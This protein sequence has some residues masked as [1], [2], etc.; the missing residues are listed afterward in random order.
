MNTF[1][2]DFSNFIL[3]NY[4]QEHDKIKEEQV[5][6]CIKKGTHDFF[7]KKFYNEHNK[8]VKDDLFKKIVFNTL[9]KNKF[10]KYCE[11]FNVF[12]T[13]IYEYD[14][15]YIEDIFIL[16]K[17][18]KLLVYDDRISIMRDDLMLNITADSI[19][20]RRDRLTFKAHISNLRSPINFEIFKQ[21]LISFI[22]NVKIEAK[23][24]IRFYIEMKIISNQF[25]VYLN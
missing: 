23:Y 5:S 14:C 18:K 10:N 9:D 3:N 20:N 24:Y 19:K 15:H 13:S 12:I 17:F 6:E 22:S 11:F 21:L 8:K 4:K 16:L 1:D 25:E 2:I 7:E